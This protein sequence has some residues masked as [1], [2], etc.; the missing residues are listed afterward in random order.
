MLRNI[1]YAETRAEAER[2]RRVFTRW[3]GDNSYDAAREAIRTGLGA[4]DQPG[5]VAVR[6]AAAQDRCGQALQEGGQS[7]SCYLA[8]VTAGPGSS[9]SIR[10]RSSQAVRSPGCWRPTASRSAWTAKA[11]AWTTRSSSG[12]GGRSSTRRCTSRHTRAAVRRGPVQ[13][14]TSTS[15]TPAGHTRRWV[16]RPRLRCMVASPK[17]QQ[18]MRRRRSWQ[19][20]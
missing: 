3:C 15:T 18:R 13:V 5:R 9:T 10:G 2:L 8:D 19:T 12:C 11:D 1:P 16:I 14:R 20:G 4:Y 17:G 6:C 7:D